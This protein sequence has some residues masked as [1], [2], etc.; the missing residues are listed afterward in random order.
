MKASKSKL[1]LH[2]LGAGDI[3]KTYSLP[4][5]LLLSLSPSL[6]LSHTHTHTYTHIHI[7]PLISTMASNHFLFPSF[8][9]CLNV[10]WII[11]SWNESGL[12]WL[13]IFFLNRN[14]KRG[15]G[16]WNS[17][18]RI[19]FLGSWVNFSLGYREKACVFLGTAYSQPTISER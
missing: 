16:W 2:N 7:S 6:C 1:K 9:T 13:L 12:G 4:L 8:C 19:T 17:G 10:N 11:R 5:S 3:M 15:D 14:Q 18:V